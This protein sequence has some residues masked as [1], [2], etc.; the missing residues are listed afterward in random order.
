MTRP[1]LS[2][3]ATPLLV[4]LACALLSAVFFAGLAGEMLEGGTRQFDTVVRQFVHAHSSGALTVVM[5]FFSILGS[6]LFVAIAASSACVVL[7]VAGERRKALVLAITVAG[8]SLLMLALKTGFHRQRPEPFF[9]TRLPA[10]YSFPSGHAL[11]SF[12]LWGAGA[13]LLS[14]SQEKRWIRIAIWT[15]ASALVVTIGYSRIYL[16]VHYPS[17][18]LAGYLAAL[19]WVLGVGIACRKTPE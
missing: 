8:G 12:C 14:S 11:L 9:D 17:D 19:V 5:Q 7:L 18:V 1:Q 10:S 3:L 13:V 16:G 6:G 2:R 15:F 4:S